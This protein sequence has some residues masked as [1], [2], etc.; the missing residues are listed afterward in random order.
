MPV[1]FLSDEQA[2]R[3]GTSVIS[4]LSKKGGSKTHILH[5][6]LPNVKTPSAISTVLEMP[7]GAGSGPAAPCAL[8]GGEAGAET[9][10]LSDLLANS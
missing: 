1:D 2:K 9:G 10:G 6:P 8:P 5:E 4:G 3:S 7:R